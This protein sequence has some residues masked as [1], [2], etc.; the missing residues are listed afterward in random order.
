MK[1]ILEAVLVIAVFAA[2]ATAQ[3][4]FDVISVKPNDSRDGPS[5]LRVSPQRYSWTNASLRQLIQVAYDVRPYQLVALPAWADSA[6]FDVAAT[7]GV[8]ASPQQMNVM[9]QNL[10]ADRFDLAVHREQRDLPAYALV[11]ARRDGKLG[12]AIH[13]ST[14]NCES[15]AGRRLDSAAAQAEYLG[16]NPQMGLTRL[17]LGGYSMSFLTGGL[18]RILEKP[19]VDKTGLTGTFD[20]ELMWTPDPTMLPA[21][22]PAPPNVPSG[23]PSI[24]TA[25]EEQ[26]GLKLISDRASVDVLIIDHLS[27]P[28]PD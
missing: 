20:M 8:P 11:V 19:V 5:D 28:K 4:S 13:P 7:T 1:K 26:L 15:A 14:K 12:P 16:C 10:L 2:L 18:K 3:K 27:K 24:F 25:L 6:D 23:G 21:G 9:L 17:K 22:V